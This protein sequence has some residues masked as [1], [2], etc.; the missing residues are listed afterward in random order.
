MLYRTLTLSDAERKE[1]IRRLSSIVAGF[2]V[3]EQRLTP[4]SARQIREG[5]NVRIAD[6]G[7]GMDESEG[8][9]PGKEPEGAG[10]LPD[11]PMAPEGEEPTEVATPSEEAA[12]EARDASE[13]ETL[14]S[15][16]TAP[17]EAGAR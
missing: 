15:A 7:A 5:T 10:E 14:P 3:H 11:E 16:S 6:R 12:A 13:G 9:T 8:R 2:D 17:G 4:H 1:R